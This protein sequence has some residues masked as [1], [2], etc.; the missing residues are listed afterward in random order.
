MDFH[1]ALVSTK[2]AEV[3][4]WSRPSAGCMSASWRSANANEAC[5]TRSCVQLKDRMDFSYD[6]GLACL[7]ANMMLFG[8]LYVCLLVPEK[9]F[10]GMSRKNIVRNII[11]SSKTVKD[12]RL[13]SQKM[14]FRLHLKIFTD[15]HCEQVVYF[16]RLSFLS[17]HD[18]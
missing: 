17:T 5:P 3:L 13:F 8:L 15:K 12:L 4:V 2:R 14:F 9:S 1:S 16:V 18:I 6:C 7:H 10:K 11:H